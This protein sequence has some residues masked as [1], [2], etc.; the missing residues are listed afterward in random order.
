MKD[1]IYAEQYKITTIC[2]DSYDNRI[3]SGRLYNPFFENGYYFRSTMELL[4][5]MDLLLTQ[6]N[7]PQAFTQNKVFL[8][9]KDVDLG[10]PPRDTMQKGK[11]ATFTVSVLFRQNVSWQGFVTWSEGKREKSFRSVLELLLLM[12]SVLEETEEGGYVIGK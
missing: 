11:S 9:V 12:D 8:P 3:L 6:M 10:N 4:K 1:N 7:L 5:K 2:I